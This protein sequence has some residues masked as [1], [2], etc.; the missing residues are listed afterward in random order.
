MH[1][2][3][4]IVFLSYL[5]FTKCLSIQTSDLM[6]T[7]TSNFFILTYTHSGLVCNLDKGRKLGEKIEKKNLTNMSVRAS[8]RTGPCLRSRT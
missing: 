3:T 8:T 4:I 2:N 7:D 5:R 1:V 6:D